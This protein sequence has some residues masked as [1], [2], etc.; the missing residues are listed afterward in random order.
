MGYRQVHQRTG[1][2]LSGSR[3]EA[4]NS[5]AH[6]K[7]GGGGNGIGGRVP[8]AIGSTEDAALG[9]LMGPE[10]AVHL[11]SKRKGRFVLSFCPWDRAASPLRLGHPLREPE[12][13]QICVAHP[14]PRASDSGTPRSQSCFVDKVATSLPPESQHCEPP[15][16]L[17]SAQLRPGGGL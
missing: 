14:Q 7:K 3:E 5:R 13:R 16:A 4:M 8:G 11:F 10:E 15:T 17:P 1:E 9:D 6:P 2:A 12:G